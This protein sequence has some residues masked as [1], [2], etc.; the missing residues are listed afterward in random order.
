[1]EGKG[2]AA[3]DNIQYNITPNS[4]VVIPSGKAHSY[5]ADEND[6]WT[7]FWVHF[8]GITA[9]AIVN[10]MIDQFMGNVGAVTYQQ[11]RLDLFNDIYL[12]LERGFGIDNLCYAN[13]CLSHFLSS[14]LYNDKF[15]INEKKQSWNDDMIERSI[16]F[17]QR[18]LSQS[19]QLSQIAQEINISIPHFCFLFRKKT[20]FAPMEYFTQLKVQK[21][22]QYLLFTDLPIKN[23]AE[24]L[25]IQDPYYFSRMFTKLMGLS[26]RQYRTKKIS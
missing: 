13:L 25:G 19:L 18:H 14:F 17:M 15:N 22:C 6:S 11:K 23:I 21:A 10:E 12:N 16:D 24:Q 2:V 9:D 1:V 26:P 20:G 8:K 7:I 3:I 5:A 4:F